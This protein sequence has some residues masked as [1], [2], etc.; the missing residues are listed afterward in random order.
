M[1]TTVEALI[2]LYVAKG[3]EASTVANI[4]T[5]PEMILALAAIETSKSAKSNKN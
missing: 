1:N 4:T 2:A 3:G 5:I